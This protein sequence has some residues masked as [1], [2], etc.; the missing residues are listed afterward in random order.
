MV[1]WL[2]RGGLIYYTRL[3]YDRYPRGGRFIRL[4]HPPVLCKVVEVGKWNR[5]YIEI[6]PLPECADK[7]SGWTE[8]AVYPKDLY[9][10]Y[11]EAVVQWNTNLDDAL[12]TLD[13]AG[14]L[15]SV[16]NDPDRLLSTTYYFSSHT[17]IPKFSRT[18][19]INWETLKKDGRIPCR[20]YYIMEDKIRGIEYPASISCVSNLYSDSL[21]DTTTGNI[22][23]TGELIINKKK[24]GEGDYGQDIYTSFYPTPGDA[25]LSYI[26]NFNKIKED[27][28]VKIDKE[29]E[30]IIKK[31]KIEL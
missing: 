23:Y 4:A 5:S 3:E 17:T 18:V 7:V 16:I 29:K 1:D 31:L 9:R 6:E 12:K 28:L 11:K 25:Y 24:V 22:N 27:V 19:D 10:T 8:I 21:Y 15:Y 20:C 13:G 2:K 30:K 26:Q 14:K